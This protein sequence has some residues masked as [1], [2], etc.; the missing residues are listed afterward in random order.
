MA[1]Q[2]GHMALM[3]S[4]MTYNV[5]TESNLR[6]I[7]ELLGIQKDRGKLLEPSEMIKVGI[8]VIAISRVKKLVDLSVSSP[9][10]DYCFKA[11]P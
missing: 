4:C 7:Q 10:L 6:S 1:L 9:T 8:P 11:L 3:R 5:V 2:Y